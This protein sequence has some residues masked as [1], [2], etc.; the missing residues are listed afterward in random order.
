MRTTLDLDDRLM[1]S[2]RRRALE[3]N[4]TLK[5]VIN[6]ALRDSIERGRTRATGRTRYT[7]PAYSMGK[8]RVDLDKALSLADQLEDQAVSSK[9][10][11]R[12]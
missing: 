8:P 4:R 1:R 11:M 12:K 3:E 7:C 5:E 9:L 6:R 2:I 10:E